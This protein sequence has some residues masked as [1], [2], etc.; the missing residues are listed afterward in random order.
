MNDDNMTTTK[1]RLKL[2]HGLKID[3][4]VEGDYLQVRIEWAN[5]PR[6]VRDYLTDTCG[7]LSAEV[8]R[9]IHDAQVRF[10]VLSAIVPARLEV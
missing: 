10:A 2:G 8:Y 7:A 6:E 4:D 9:E 1:L 3:S 5:T